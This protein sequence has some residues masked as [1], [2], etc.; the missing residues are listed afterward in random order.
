MKWTDRKNCAL[1]V[2]LAGL[3]GCA[4]YQIGTRSLYPA[5]IQTVYVPIFESSS[6]RRNLGE[7]LTEAVIKE[8]ELK[9]PYKV[10]GSPD[11]DSVLAGRI[12]GEGKRLI[13]ESRN[14]EPREVQANL[15]VEVSWNDRRGN[16][17]RRADPI[18]LRRPETHERRKR[19][20]A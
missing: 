2:L 15:Q 16:V 8:V 18:P 11:A 12:V 20:A 3:A 4:G 9:T 10:T 7:R 13:V 1:L 6:F 14:G 17:I 19:R 5:H